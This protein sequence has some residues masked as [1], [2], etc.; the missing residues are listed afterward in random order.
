VSPEEHELERRSFR[1][2]ATLDTLR[3]IEKAVA[4]DCKRV[5]TKDEAAL[6]K[7]VWKRTDHAV[8]LYAATLIVE[9]QK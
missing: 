9:A 8:A 3:A 4:E 2:K 6:A 7:I 1:I 5:V